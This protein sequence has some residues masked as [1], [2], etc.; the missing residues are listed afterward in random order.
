M[1][2][3]E[4]NQLI[5]IPYKAFVTKKTSNAIAGKYLEIF[6]RRNNLRDYWV[7]IGNEL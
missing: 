3:L 1:S 7:S 4:L 5:I 2:L 6:A